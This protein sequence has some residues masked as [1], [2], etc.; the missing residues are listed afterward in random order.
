[1]GTALEIIS[2]VR[3]D[4]DLALV[5]LTRKFDWPDMGEQDIELDMK[6]AKE[7]LLSLDAG[8]RKSLELAAANIS[9]FHISQRQ[10]SWS[11]MDGYGTR[12]GQRMV[13]LKSAGIYVPGGSAAYPSTVLMCGLA[14][15]AAG[16]PNV[17]MC[18]PP[19]KDGSINKATLAAAEIA[20]VDRIFR[21]GGAQ[22][23][24]ALA[25]STKSVPA[26]DVIAGP[27]NAYVTAAKRAVMGD[28][29]VDM[30]AGPSE[31]MVVAD[32]TA[33]PSFIAAD[34]IAQAEHD[35]LA[36]CTLVTTSAGVLGKVLDELER[37]LL[38]APRQ[39]IARAALESYSACIMAGSLEEAIGIADKFAPE[40]LE[41]CC[42]GA[43]ALAQMASN[44]GTI[45]VGNYSA[46]AM[47]DYVAGPSHVLPTMGTARFRGTLSTSDFQK[48][49][50]V[51]EY[52][53]DGFLAEGPAAVVLAKEEGL[54]GH[55]SSV[56]VRLA[57]GSPLDAESE[58]VAGFKPVKLDAN[59]CSLDVP[60]GAKA[61]ILGSLMDIPFNRYPSMDSDRLR[62][63]LSERFGI[64][65][66]R[67]VVGVGS[68]EMIMVLMLALRGKVDRVVSP[69]PSFSMYRGISSICGLPFEAIGLGFDGLPD[70]S[71]L[72]EALADERA[73]VM[74]CVPNNPTGD[75]MEKFVRSKI[76]TSKA[77]VAIDQAYAEF[78]GSDMSDMASGRT[79]I[80][81]TF[82][83]AR[84][85]AGIRVG[86]SISGEEMAELLK[87]G[88]ASLQCAVH[89]RGDR[90][91]GP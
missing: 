34:L 7:A 69:W 85:L 2:K 39:A 14:A 60:A 48:A 3:A 73:L 20:G 22:A 17:Y 40:H 43:A 19:G 38:I 46:E 27:G 70:E 89:L 18:T 54:F 28:V 71:A 4:G 16:V 26:V 59:E 23:I 83:K 21:I 13:P 30:L 62:A 77:Y 15:K 31:L 72:D 37:Q 11:Y 63:R 91:I 47:G 50:N 58:R 9:R 61:R 86:Y 79:V 6:L 56:S 87:K 74:L 12:L 82:S 76:P 64:E 65:A 51:V 35:E 81:R 44:A 88:Q 1:M 33:N 8:V 29:R 66:S 53:K 67:F 84:R 75:S 41:L 36:C 57:A 49:V 45:F 68:D 42:E 25:Y 80:L 52:S 90:H 32:E 55:A 10:A 5:E 78:C 24:A